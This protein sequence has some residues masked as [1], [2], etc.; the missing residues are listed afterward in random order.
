MES[1][2]RAKSGNSLV[3]VQDLFVT[4]TSNYRVTFRPLHTRI[5]RKISVSMETVF[6]ILAPILVTMFV[7]GAAGCVIVI[8]VVAYRLFNV[9]VEPDTPDEQ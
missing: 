9:L 1:A 7:I 4:K 3:N 6:K 5:C 2:G 8:P